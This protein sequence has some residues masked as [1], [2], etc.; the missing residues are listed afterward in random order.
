M[1]FLD[2][3]KLV[4]LSKIPFSTW[5]IYGAIGVGTAIA[6]AIAYLKGKTEQLAPSAN[7]I[8]REGSIADMQPILEMAT[9]MK[10]VAAHLKSIHSILQHEI[11]RKREEE[12]ADLKDENMTLKMELSSIKRRLDRMGD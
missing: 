4:E 9:T 2:P 8:I 11:V 5:F 6:A 1:E 3:A 10:E 12:V 7:M